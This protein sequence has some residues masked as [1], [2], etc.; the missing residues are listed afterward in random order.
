LAS[1]SLKGLLKALRKQWL[2][3]PY[4]KFDNL[5]SRIANC[6]LETAFNKFVI[7]KSMKEPHFVGFFAAQDKI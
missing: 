4:S 2:K 5:L 3:G 6:D 7:L 1:S